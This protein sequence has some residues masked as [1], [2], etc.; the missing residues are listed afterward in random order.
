MRPLVVIALLGAGISFAQAQEQDRKLLDRIL[1]PDTSLS[2]AAQGKRFE[3]GGAT[4]TK[5]APTKSFSFFNR[6]RVKQFD[7]AKTYDAKA[8]TTKQSQFANRTANTSS[9]SDIRNVEKP[10]ATGAYQTTASPDN[11]RHVEV[12][13]YPGSRPFLVRGKSQKALSAQDRPLTIDE[14]RELLNKNK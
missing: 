6:T 2:N 10:Y 4:L 3:A 12:A 8:F 7:A 9:R 11:G 5:A 13:E 14:V 1:K